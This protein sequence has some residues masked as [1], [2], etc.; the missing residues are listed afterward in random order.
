MFEIAVCN[1]CGEIAIVGKDDGNGKLVRSSIW[2]ERNFYQVHFEEDLY[3]YE[4]DEDDNKEDIK[5]KN[6]SKKED[7]KFYLCKS[8][9]AIVAEDEVHNSW[10]T[11]GNTQKI[12]LTKVKL[13]KEKKAHCLNCNGTLRRFDLGYD[14]ATG[15]VATSLYEQIPEYKF[16]VEENAEKQSTNNPFL[17]KAEKKKSK[18]RTGSQFLIFSDSRQGAAKFACFLSDSYKEFPTPSR[19]LE[20]RNTKEN[21]FRN[22]IGISDFVSVLDNYYSGLNLFRKSNSENIES[23]ITEIDV[24]P[25]LLFL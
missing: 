4:E 2:N 7:T 12:S 23:S 10:C 6:R 5:T 24:M 16:D 9:G 20:C 1:D 25:G 14:A 15:V 21:N 22:G 13:S 11:C 8:C 3:E 17:Q 19:N 18:S